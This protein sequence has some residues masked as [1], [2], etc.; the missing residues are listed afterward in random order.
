MSKRPTQ[1]MMETRK[2]LLKDFEFWAKHSCKIRTKQGEIVSLVLN[3]V[4]KRFLLGIIDQL[5]TTGRIRYV[6]RK[7]ITNSGRIEA[8]S[9]YA[10][11]ALGTTWTDHDGRLRPIATALRELHRRRNAEVA[12]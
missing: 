11:S 3:R 8:Q 9:R 2:R 6:I 5:E 10:R 4:Q 7:G 12:L 1:Q